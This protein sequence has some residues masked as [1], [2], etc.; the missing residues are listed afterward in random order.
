[1]LHRKKVS[2]VGIF[3]ALIAYSSQDFQ[4]FKMM[5]FRRGIGETANC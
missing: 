3:F 4:H 1:M 2:L 5:H